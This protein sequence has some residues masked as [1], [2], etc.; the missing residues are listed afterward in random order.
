MQ[1]IIYIYK[2]LLGPFTKLGVF[3]KPHIVCYVW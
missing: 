2:V 3:I 1:Y